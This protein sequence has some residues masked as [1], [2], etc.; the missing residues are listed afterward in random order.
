M[1]KGVKVSYHTKTVTLSFPWANHSPSFLK[2]SLNLSSYLT[3]RNLS[4]EK[5]TTHSVYIG[6]VK[7]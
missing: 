1:T 4:L 6:P 5:K 7:Q 3:T 2:A